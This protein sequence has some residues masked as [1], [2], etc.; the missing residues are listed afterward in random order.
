MTSDKAMNGQGAY[1]FTSSH[2][3]TASQLSYTD[4]PEIHPAH[5]SSLKGSAEQR[6]AVVV[7][8]VV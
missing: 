4:S 7:V 5:L 8:V 3:K 6:K 1:R 2:P